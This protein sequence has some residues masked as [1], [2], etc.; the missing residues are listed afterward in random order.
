MVRGAS[1]AMR[2]PTALS[3][4]FF[5][6]MPASAGQLK[7]ASHSDGGSSLLQRDTS[8]NERRRDVAL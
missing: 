8:A 3:S 1:P 5:Q 7:I 2:V 4:T 6:Q